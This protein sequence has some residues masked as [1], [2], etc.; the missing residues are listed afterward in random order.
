MKISLLLFIFIMFARTS[1]AQLEKKLD[2]VIAKNIQPGEPGIAV[3]V[4]HQGKT[5]YK[6]G[7]GLGNSNGKKI[8]ASTNF[9]MASVS[10]QFTAMCI[11]LL[12]KEGQISFEDYVS[13]FLPEIPAAVGNKVSIR[14]LL[15]HSSGVIDYEDIMDEK[16]T[17]QLL[18][19]DVLSLL[20]KQDSTYFPPGSRFQYSNS[21]Y[22]LLCLIIE[23]ASGKTF[24]EFVEERI[25]KPLKMKH[26][27]IYED[28][29]QIYNRAMGFARDEN[30]SLYVNDQS[31]TSAVKGDGGVYTSLNDYKKWTDALWQDK[32]V[33]LPDV[34]TR[35]NFPV[36]EVTGSFYGPGWFYFDKD[37]PSL[38]HSGSTCGFSTFS[39]NIPGQKTSIVYFSNIANNSPPFKAILD[40]LASAGIG[41]PAQVFRLHELTR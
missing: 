19:A 25:F 15:T 32:L 4:E 28:S 20:S 23:R 1:F 16:Q 2:S 38:F 12:E 5:V 22:A 33:N 6:K 8:S 24:P 17:V 40:I 31:T 29:A 13:R 11:L 21:A 39:I 41:N 36:K 7:F 3:Y 10:K 34:M 18:D 35:L 27:L 14:H 30:K 26:S 9:R 37:Q